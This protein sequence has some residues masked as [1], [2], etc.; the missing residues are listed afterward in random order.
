MFQLFRNR[1]HQQTEKTLQELNKQI[2]Q[3]EKQLE[4]LSEKGLEHQITIETL[5]V[6]DPV[7]ENLTF[8]FDKIELDEVSG[9]LNM[10]NNFGITVKQHSNKKQGKKKQQSK[11]KED[12]NRE[13]QPH[14]S[15]FTK[16]ENGFH[17]KF[18]QHD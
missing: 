9:A 14:E 18:G 10:G 3:M 7:L 1:A 2:K 5:N 6:K 15:A 8:K 12:K 16:T 4:Q 13:N 11:K 17:F